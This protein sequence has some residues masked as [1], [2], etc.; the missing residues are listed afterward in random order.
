[1]SVDRA[2]ITQAE[3]LEDN[4]RYEQTFDAF[5]HFVCEVHAGFSENRLDEIARLIVQMRVSGIRH[6]AVQ[7]A[8]DRSDIFCDRPFIVVEHNDEALR[9][10]FDVIE[11]FVADSAGESGIA[12]DHYDVLVT[13]AQVASD[14][15]A[16]CR[17][18]RR[19]CVTCSITVVFAFCP[20]KKTVEPAKLA[21]R[22]KTV[23]TPGK[24]FVHVALMADIHHEAV[25]RRVEHAMQG[26]RQLDDTEI[27]P[28]MSAGLGKNL[29]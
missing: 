27:R 9:M 12:C 13:A 18:K 29:N 3:F 10:R 2:V 11:R 21:H 28:Q 17:R 1:V 19:A 26:N 23:E 16:E 5:F 24:H 20:Q 4:A 8:C 25:T 7:V 14:R 6:N 15:H 22:M